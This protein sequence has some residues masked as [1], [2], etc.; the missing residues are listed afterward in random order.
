[1]RRPSITL[2]I[3]LL[4]TA[5][6]SHNDQPILMRG[7]KPLALL[8]YL[9]ITGKAHSREH[10]VDLLFDGPGD[11]KASLRWTLSELRKGIGVAHILADRQQIGF[12]FESDYWLDV[13]E[14]EAG[15]LDLYR[16]DFLEGFHLRDSFGFEDWAFFERERF[17]GSYQTA[18][19]RQGAE[20]ES[21]GDVPVV[22]ET[23]HRLLRLDNLR[24]DWYRLLMR[25]YA[26]QGKREAALAQ[27]DQCRQVLQAELDVEPI[28]ETLALAE[29][30]QQGR[31][32]PGR[33]GPA[34]PLP[35]SAPRPRFSTSL[36]GRAPE[37]ERLRRIWQQTTGAKGQIVLVEGEPGIGKTRLLEELLTE[38]AGEAI[39]LRA[40]CP[41][42]RQPLAYTLLVDP[43]RAVLFGAATS[44]PIKGSLSDVWLAPLS[45][46]LPDLSNRYPDLP[47]PPPLDLA[48]E[49]RRLFDAICAILLSLTVQQPLVLFVDDLQWADSTS[50]E[51]LNH[52][53][54]KMS[55]TP[56]LILGTYR[57]H[58]VGPD[59]PLRRSRREWQRAGLLTEF[60]LKPLS[61]EAMV[62]LLRELTTWPGDDPSFGDLVYRETAGNP[63]FVVETIASLRD[64]GRLPQDVAGWQRDFRAESVAIPRQVQTLIEARLNR[65]DDLSRQIIT[66]A[67]VMRSSFRADTVQTASGRNELETLEGLERLLANGL[68]VE[69]GAEEFTFSH[70]KIREVAYGSLSQLRRK[71]LHR[72]VAETLEKRYRG[73]EAVIAGRLAYHFEQAGDQEKA[74]AYHLEA[75]H[76]AKAQYAHEAAIEHYQKAVALLKAQQDFEHAAQ[77][78][79]QL[80]L[81]QHQVF[82]FQGAQQAY[83]EAFALRQQIGDVLPSTSPPASYTLRTTAEGEPDTLDPTLCADTTSGIIIGQLF[84]GLVTETPGMELVPDVAQRWE[85]LADGRKYIFHL[86]SDVTWSDGAPVTATDFEYAWKRVLNPTFG[87]V[88]ANML[89][90]VKG[91]SAF[92]QGLVSNPDSVGVSTLDKHTLTVELERPA[93]YFLSL[94]AVPITLPVPQHVVEVHGEAWT[95]VENIVTNG[96]FTLEAWQKGEVMN[97]RRNRAYHG[98]FRGNVERVE[99]FFSGDDLTTELAWYEAGRLDVARRPSLK[100]EAKEQRS[101]EHIIHPTLRTYAL[102]F[103]KSRPPF[104]DPRVRR[105]FVLASN[106]PG[107]FDTFSEIYGVPA[108]GGLCP[109]GMPGHSADIG[110][111][112]DPI[113]ARQLL[114]EAGYPAGR[115]FPEINWLMNEFL[116]P[117]AGY[118]QEQW[119][120]NLGIPEIKKV[121]G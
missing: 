109:P 79:M 26:Q 100:R 63:L 119:Q 92:H 52:L 85:I 96:P 33:P 11:P 46:L 84:S 36:V 8:A 64:E 69:Q 115:N 118:L 72:R 12:N 105:A 49:R 73:R 67:A 61:A 68:L 39:I 34:I 114:A 97:L 106:R 77:I 121:V 22:I 111:P 107:L 103:D 31:F 56:L 40:K 14:F 81:V 101:G 104:D 90:D 42:L 102:D 120:T 7:Y 16:G 93:S 53:S 45:R 15:Q 83:E 6:L 117:L 19:E 76:A 1:M 65:L 95:D 47:P 10:L 80:G 24:E 88:E 86:R 5:Q 48:A 108:T 13:N 98:L 30:I 70:D 58:E 35:S 23:A 44:T 25:A 78:S 50:L 112:Y 37:M 43:L 91:A 74:L 41:E 17:R 87:S 82:D 27:F 75:G 71:L 20:A 66:T 60:A 2:R 110:L 51:V 59:H 54:S 89:Y 9:L 116:E 62:G 32:E 29:A 3:R 21:R 113:Q 94:L 28:A 99:V 18:L 57:A 38:V 4:G 55:Q